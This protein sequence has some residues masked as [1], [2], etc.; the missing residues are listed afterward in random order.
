MLRLFCI[1]Q[2]FYSFNVYCGYLTASVKL[3]FK[4]DSGVIEF[5]P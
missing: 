3:T 1:M 2:F 4:S 5:E